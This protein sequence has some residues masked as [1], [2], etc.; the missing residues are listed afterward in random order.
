MRKYAH[1]AVSCVVFD[2]ITMRTS[3]FKLPLLFCFPLYYFLWSFPMSCTSGEV[4][5]NSLLT[6]IHCDYY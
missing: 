4:S 1:L 3:G 6:I 5:Y 2:L